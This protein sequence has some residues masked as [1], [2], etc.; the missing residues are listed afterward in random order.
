MHN[1]THI[2]KHTGLP[3]PDLH[4]TCEIDTEKRV[5]SFNTG[6]HLD[7]MLFIDYCMRLEKE[8]EILIV[9]RQSKDT[10]GPAQIPGRFKIELTL[11]GVLFGVKI[12]QLGDWTQ[13]PGKPPLFTMSMVRRS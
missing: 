12:V 1:H 3:I 9:D 13:L 5:V 8:E 4:F 10:W 11:A 6:D 2:F 7:S